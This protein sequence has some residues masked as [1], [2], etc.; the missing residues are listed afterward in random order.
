MSCDNLT[1]F[2]VLKLSLK[3]DRKKVTA[4]NFTYL[5]IFGRHQNLKIN[6][7]SS[8]SWLSSLGTLNENSPREF[9]LSFRVSFSSLGLSDDGV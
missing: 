1:R 3:Y 2:F 5:L 6:F 9:G 7:T 4:N 8:T